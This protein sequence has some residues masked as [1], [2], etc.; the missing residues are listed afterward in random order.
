M[1]KRFHATVQEYTSVILSHMSR[2][3]K[4]REDDYD[5]NLSNPR[6]TG[7]DS[8]NGGDISDDEEPSPCDGESNEIINPATGYPFDCTHEACPTGSFCR[9]SSDSSMADTARCCRRG[10]L[11]IRPSE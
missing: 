4:L 1:E 5:D 10:M 7:V 6:G 2:K 3:M 8:N 9:H 11:Y